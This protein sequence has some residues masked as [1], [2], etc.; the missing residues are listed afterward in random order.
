MMTYNGKLLNMPGGGG[1]VNFSIG[2][3]CTDPVI[4]ASGYTSLILNWTNTFTSSASVII[5]RKLTSGGTFA[6]VY[7]TLPQATTYTDN[8]LTSGVSYTYRLRPTYYGVYG[9]YT[10]EVVK[11]TDALID[12]DGNIY[13]T[14]VI[15]TQ[16]WVN[17]NLKTTKYSDGSTIP[18]ITNSALW[19]ADRVGALCY[20][21]NNEAQYKT[22]YGAL[23]NY[24][25]ISNPLDIVYL[26][27]G[28]NKEIGWRVP[29][30]TDYTTL[31]N[32]LGGESVAGGKLK[33]AGFLHWISP[34]EGAT[35]ESLLTI[36][37]SGN[38]TS[39]GYFFGDKSSIVLRTST[40][41][42]SYSYS[43]Y[44]RYDSATITTQMYESKRTGGAIRLMRNV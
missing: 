24:F 20:Y 19:D 43:K 11:S 41:N 4:T 44:M 37:P 31:I 12:M 33:E 23:Y 26:K 30:N 16:E 29:T 22:T 34:N 6:P 1:N 32:N 28:D 39:D 38:R 17:Q 5:E 2:G 35:N 36:L 21:N 15:G 3:T 14:T 13:T 8:G 9:G 10:A 18:N 27:R 42:S 25:S 7:T 40:E